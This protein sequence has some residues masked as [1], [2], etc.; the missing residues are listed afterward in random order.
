MLWSDKGGLGLLVLDWL[1]LSI[2]LLLSE[3]ALDIL[4]K[5]SG[6]LERVGRLERLDRGL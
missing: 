6:G 1:L 4:M 3:E 5:C 2:W